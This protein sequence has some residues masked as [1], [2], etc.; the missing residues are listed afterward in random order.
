MKKIK[1]LIKATLTDNMNL[2]KLKSKNQREKTR[3]LLPIILIIS[4]MITVSGYASMLIEPLTKIHL[5]FVLLTLFIMITVIMTLIEGIY[6]SSSLLFNCKD[7]DLLLSLPIKKST[8]LFIRI[9]KFYLF[10]LA[11]NSVILIPAM[12]V[13]SVYV[14]VG[15]SYYIISFLSLFILPIIPIVISGIIGGIISSISSQFKYKNI[16]EILLTTVFLL[17]ILYGYMN[18]DNILENIGENAKNINDVIT[19][20]YYPAGAYINLITDFK[21]LDFIKFSFINIGIFVIAILLLSKMYYKI[22]SNTKIVKKSQ[23]TKNYR[24]RQK[25]QLKALIDK[26]FNKFINSPVFVTNAGFGLV[27]YVIGCIYLSIKFDN[28]VN[29]IA[30]SG[31]DISSIPISAYI[32]VILFILIT[33]GSL[34]SS[35][36]SSMIS[37]EGK[38]FSTI[39]S[40]PVSPSLIITSKVLTAVIIMLPF[41]FFGS[42][43][44]F[45]NFDFSIVEIITLFIS[46]IILPLVSETIGIIVNIKY[47]KMNAE[48]DTEVVKQSMSSFI[49]VLIG[50]VLTMITCYILVTLILNNISCLTILLGATSVYIII[51]LLLLLYL[52]K[53]GVKEFNSITI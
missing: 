16:V 46:L 17:V 40:L 25:S 37:L 21:I 52:N 29:L 23:N 12:I 3:K 24:I 18:I 14:K 31:L 1:S 44:V 2:F 42:I 35:I 13:Y 15:L 7:D 22:N 10:E 51:Y 50:M 8:V 4:V 33:M 45:I 41:M 39:K 49:S 19:K 47:P 20:L 28:I 6:K 30:M 11:F 27:I 48:N 9:L 34:M 38:N 32:P 43:I 5:E 26:E 36:T 53:K